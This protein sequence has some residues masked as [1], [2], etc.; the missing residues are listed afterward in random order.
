MAA[1]AH[2][3]RRVQQ[4]VKEIATAARITKRVYPHLLR[5]THTV[6]QRLLEDGRWAPARSDPGNSARQKNLTQVHQIR[7]LKASRALRPRLAAVRTHP[8]SWL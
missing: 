6:A 5:H 7:P 3:P 2:I 8:E 4:L 1:R